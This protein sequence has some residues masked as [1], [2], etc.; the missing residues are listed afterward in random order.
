MCRYSYSTKNL[1]NRYMHLTNYSIN[2][3]NER[4]QSN[5]GNHDCE[6]HKW[7]VGF[8]TSLTH[9]CHNHGCEG[10]KWYVG[11]IT[12][13]IHHCQNHDCEGHKWYVGFIT[14]LIKS[15]HVVPA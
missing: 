14:S 11:F 12:S 8:I 3:Q 5:T 6:G 13:L 2:K 1:G 7:Y 4:Y 9:H 10:H 15:R